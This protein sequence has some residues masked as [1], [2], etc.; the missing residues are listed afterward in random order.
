MG[1]NIE[2]VQKKR[3]KSLRNLDE[4]KNENSA[5]SADSRMPCFLCA[6]LQRLIEGLASAGGASEEKLRFLVY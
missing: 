6:S 3:S 2:N 4:I 5:K 1:L